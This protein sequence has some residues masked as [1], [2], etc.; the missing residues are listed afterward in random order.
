M[1]RSAHPAGPRHADVL[2]EGHYTAPPANLNV[3]DPK[4][5]FSGVVW[6][7]YFSLLQVRRSFGWHGRWSVVMSGVGF[8]GLAFVFLALDWLLPGFHAYGG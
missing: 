8:V 7:W 1:S 4:V 2:P 5:W 6:A 3:L